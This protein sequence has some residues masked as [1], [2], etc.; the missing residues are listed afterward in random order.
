MLRISGFVL[1]LRRQAVIVSMLVAF[2]VYASG[3]AAAIIDFNVAAGTYN[4]PGNWLDYTTNTMVVP[5]NLDEAVVR[6][7][8]TLTISAAD[9]DAN[10]A[11]IR[12]GAGPLTGDPVGPPTPPNGPGT[13][14]F[15]GAN[16]FGAAVTGARLDVGQR[17]NTNNIDY[18]GIV[19]HSGGKIALNT[20]GGGGSF[21]NI[22][23]SGTTMTPTSVYNLSSNG[24]IGLI[25][26]AGNNNGIN[27]RNGTF[28][29]TGGQIVTDSGAFDQRAMTVSSASGTLG[30]EN[31]ASAN[32]SG[33]TV[34]VSGGM[35]MASTS[36]TQAYATISGTADLHFRG[37]DFQLA[38]N[39]TN[40]FARVDMSGGSL[41]VG[42]ATA[43]PIQDK[44]LII[45]DQGTGV[46]NL[47]G[48][49]VSLNH[50]LVVANN[51]L[52]KGTLLQTG[53]TLTVRDIETNRNSGAYNLAVENATIIVD[54]PTAVFNQQNTTALLTGETTIG[55]HGNGRFEL[56]LG[57]A[58]LRL[59]EMANQPN[60]RATLNVA[61][62]KMTIQDGVTWNNTT[63]GTAN[64]PTVN[65][66]GGELELTPAGG[67]ISWQA[68]MNLMGTDFDP[69]PGALLLTNVGSAPNKPANFSLNTGSVW[70]LN[71]AN[72]TLAGA[73]WVDV[74]NGN[75]A[76]NGGLLNIIPI[77][78]YTPA[79]GDTVRIL[80]SVNDVTLGTVARNNP[81]WVPIVAAAGK[82][83]HLTYVPEPSSML[84]F[85]I[86]L[87][88][89]SAT[90]RTT[91]RK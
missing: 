53:G 86:G 70:D 61:G 32:F 38:T 74:P 66:T 64:A 80:R 24:I 82:E 9:G 46:F 62:G 85:G 21:L 28:N 16:I 63:V 40:S 11:R 13:L 25:T 36:H 23:S 7:G 43:T 37:A 68:N 47:S 10:A 49:T 84:L 71:I 3:A 41:K 60:S 34:Y 56:R 91:S 26:G 35:R 17:D 87:A 12:I 50:S 31:V 45:G 42:D 90:R 83:I 1:P 44:R 75:G 77:G 29:M 57:R 22:G 59:V 2:L 76:L 89:F 5:T 88:M 78:G 33:G 14:E 18:T 55:N 69:K 20:T 79:I 72:G 15:T 58:N 65:L 73:D 81:N 51:A 4:V 27:V 6:N 48:G 67:A 8:G 52:S 54:G 30:S 39:A 19:N